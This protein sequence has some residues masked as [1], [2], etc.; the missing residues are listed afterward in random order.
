[1]M[2]ILG[3]KEGREVGEAL[4]KIKEQQILGKIRSKNGAKIFLK[5]GRK[6]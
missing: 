5:K 1:M 6:N 4:E 2:E 3:I